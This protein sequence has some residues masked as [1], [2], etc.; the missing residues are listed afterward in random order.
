MVILLNVLSM[1]LTFI[2][3]CAYNA[4]GMERML[5]TIANALADK[6]D[7][8]V[9]TAFNEG[10]K[11]AFAL[12]E[13]IR[14]V[15]LGLWRADYYSG[16][17]VKKTYRKVLEKW[18]QKNPQDV[19]ISLG[20]MELFFLYKIKDDSKKIVWFHF[21]LSRFMVGAPFRSIA[22]LHWLYGKLYILRYLWYSG[23]YDKVVLLSKAD[24][25]GW[26]RFVPKVTFIYNPVTIKSM[27]IEPDYSVHKAMAAGRLDY[28]KGF[29]FLIY[30]WAKVH[31]KYPDWTLDIYGEGSLHGQLQRQI[32]ELN[33]SE[34]I[35]LCGLINNMPVAYAAHS[36][37]ILSSRFEGFG[38]V[39]T[40]AASCGLPLISYDCE[41]GPSEIV[42]NGE[43]GILV[44]PVGDTDAL[45]NGIMRMMRDEGTRK[46]MGNKAKEMSKLFSLEKIIDEWI[47]LIN[48]L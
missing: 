42:I 48:S 10:R 12:K 14:R 26:K 37:F 25:K 32:D 2:I 5:S 6:Y 44:S 36:M 38:L 7:V 28:Q 22:P 21:A 9:V 34:S 29:D 16:N 3:E 47:R 17:S 1:R 31:K 18:L 27:G 45:A 43:N 23:H 8:S 13:N 30:A 19:V 39:L 35:T 40:E 33:L 11:D 20:S 41:H 24:L 4:G 46:F 15:D